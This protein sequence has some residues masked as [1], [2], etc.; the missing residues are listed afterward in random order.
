MENKKKVF[1]FLPDGVGL[2]NFAFTKFKEVG[3]LQNFEVVYWNKTD[4]DLT[5]IGLTEIKVSK[6]KSHFLTMFQ[7]PF[8]PICNFYIVRN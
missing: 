2:R 6:L 4:F 3:C 7:I 1:V 8:T 5:E